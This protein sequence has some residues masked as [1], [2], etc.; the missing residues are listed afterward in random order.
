M[1]AYVYMYTGLFRSGGRATKYDIAQNGACARIAR[2]LVTFRDT[3][4]VPDKN[5]QQGDLQG[6]NSVQRIDNTRVIRLRREDAA[7]CNECPGAK[8]FVISSR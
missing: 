8:T 6:P 7:I 3:M 5:G 4:A 1:Q 2:R